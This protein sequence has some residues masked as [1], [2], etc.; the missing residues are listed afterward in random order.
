MVTFGLLTLMLAAM[1]LCTIPADPVQTPRKTPSVK[2]VL[3][4]VYSVVSFRSFWPPTLWLMLTAST[5]FTLASLWCGLY[6]RQCADFRWSKSA[7][8][9]SFPSPTLTT[10]FATYSSSSQAKA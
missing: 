1:V 6:L 7:F 2:S 8:C 4:N 9:S 5:Y 3:R 10:Y